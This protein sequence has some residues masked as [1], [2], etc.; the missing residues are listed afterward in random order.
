M[1]LIWDTDVG[2]QV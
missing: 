1:M 2:K